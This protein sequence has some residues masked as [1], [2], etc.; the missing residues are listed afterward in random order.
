MIQM[1]KNM[2]V[3][4]TEEKPRI[5]NKPTHP[6]TTEM[7][8]SAIQNLKER[9]GSSFQAIKK[10]ISTN[11][12]IE[13]E[14]YIPFVK[15]CLKS[16]LASGAL[17]QTKGKGIAGSFKLGTSTSNKTKSKSL[18]K[19]DKT[20][21][22]ARSPKKS[23]NPKKIKNTEKANSSNELVVSS[24]VGKVSKSPAKKTKKKITTSPKVDSSTSPEKKSPMKKASSVTSINK[25]HKIVKTL[26]TKLPKPKK[27]R[28]KSITKELPTKQTTNKS[29]TKPKIIS[30]KVVVSKK[31]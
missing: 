11:Y 8:I 15:K 20:I 6:S 17:I 1:K 18:R 7:I 31:K 16:G 25:K 5:R 12:V 28:L 10:Y 9:N 14:K 21:S 23:P 26:A 22:S 19:I 2:V 24:S 4:S 29:H 30:K 27:T 13:M 3:S